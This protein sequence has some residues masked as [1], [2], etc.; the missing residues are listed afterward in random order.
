MNKEQHSLK[1][2][3]Y[4]E[5]LDGIISGAYKANQ[6]I[7]EKELVQKFGVSKSP[8]R[9]ALIALCNEGVLRNIPRYGYEVVRLT[10]R[11]VREMLRFRLILESGL[12]TESCSRFTPGQLEEL[13]HLDDLCNASVADM[14]V[15]WEHNT[16]FHLALA[17]V[18]GNSYAC[19]QLQKNMDILKRAYAQFY[20][21]KWDAEYNPVDMRYHRDLLACIESRDLDGALRNLELDLQDFRS[22]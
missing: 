21:D 6:I 1:S 9:E 16:R 7:N 4:Q 13:Y 8:V 19:Q 17:A 12:L 14:W 18:S 10:T 22:I 2:L 20:W 3:V 11:D 5:T 15:H